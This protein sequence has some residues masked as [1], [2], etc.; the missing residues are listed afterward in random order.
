MGEKAKQLSGHENFDNIALVITGSHTK[1]TEEKIITFFERIINKKETNYRTYLCQKAGKTY[2]VIFNAYGAS[3]II[4]LVPALKDGGCDT[5]IL[6]GYADGTLKNL[7]LGKIV[8]PEISYHYDGVYTVQKPVRK[9]AKPSQELKTQLHKILY[10]EQIIFVAGTNISVPAKNL[11]P[12]N[13]DYSMLHAS[14]K[15]LEL[16]SLLTAAKENNIHAAGILVIEENNTF[17]LPEHIKERMVTESKIRVL[18]TL[19]KNIHNLQV[20]KN[21]KP[22][23]SL[24]KYIRK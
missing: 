2:P 11:Q 4:D 14:T 3:A 10:N 21:K 22:Q 12:P 7:E 23:D 1:E 13:S 15:E 18:K 8:I 16:S 17:T 6:I 20:S 24:S 9:E 19:I 5:I